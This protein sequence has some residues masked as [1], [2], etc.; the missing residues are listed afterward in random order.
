MKNLRLSII[1]ILLILFCFSCQM[2]EPEPDPIP[3]QNH[4]K[5]KIAFNQEIIRR[6]NADIEL[7]AKRYNWNL[8][9]TVTGLYYQILNPTNGKQPQSRDIVTIK[10]NIMLPDGQEIYNSNVDGLK[11]IIINQSGDPIGLHEL[12]TLMHAVE[13]ANAIIPSYLA[14]GIS[15]DGMKI[16][17]VASLIC[18]VELINV[19]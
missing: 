17:A 6:E 1:S 5:E 11:E 7:I 4:E 19:K 12:L 9:Q 16:P 13:K 3:P 2:S 10:G 8:T 15:G 14:Y 18:K